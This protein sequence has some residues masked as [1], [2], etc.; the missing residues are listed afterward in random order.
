MLMFLTF[1]DLDGFSYDSDSKIDRYQKT[2][3]L[4]RSSFPGHSCRKGVAFA[5]ADWAPIA[6]SLFPGD[7]NA[8]HDEVPVRG[9]TI[10]VS[11]V[12]SYEFRS[13][14]A[15]SYDILLDCCSAHY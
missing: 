8:R 12:S 10:T 15:G 6:S 9:E 3:C 4:L 1:P 2:S 14:T 13:C 7:G 11:T 5:S